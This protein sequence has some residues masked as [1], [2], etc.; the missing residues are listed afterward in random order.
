[1]TC[2]IQTDTPDFAKEM[3]DV[4][5]LFYGRVELVD[6]QAELICCHTD[7]QEGSTRASRVVLSGVVSA[8]AQA[9]GPVSSDALTDKRVH[10]R[11]VKSALYQ[12]L[13][14]ATGMHPPWGSLTGIR[15]TRLVYARMQQ[16]RTLEQA[17]QWAQNTFDLTAAKTDLLYQVVQV[18]QSLPQPQP[19]DVDIYIGIPFCTTRC[20]YC[21]FISA[22][23]GNGKLLAP[24]TQALLAEMDRAMA[25][26]KHH[27]LRVRAFYMGG[28]TPTSLPADLLDAILAKARPWLEVA[29]EATVEAGRPDTIDRHKLNVLRRH[30][31]RRISINPQTMHDSTLAVIGRAHTRQ[32]TEDAYALAR[33]LGFDRINMDLIAGLPGETLDM[34]HQ[35]LEWA[36]TLRPENLTVHSLCIK[37]SSDMHR[38]QDSLPSGSVVESMVDAGA[39]AA[40]DMGMRAYYLYRQK[41]MAGNLENV[42]YAL[43]GT[44][45]L[46]NVDTMEDTVSILA[47][48]AGGISKR[49]WPDRVFIKRAP[50]V[51]EIAHYTARVQEMADR[52]DDLW[53]SDRPDYSS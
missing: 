42:G 2:N 1:M 27:G 10:K 45:C 35:T 33:E 13:K 17:C 7:M 23:V 31:I 39:S 24:Y 40:Q 52:K 16:G 53:Q 22:Q 21:S 19:Q 8:S 25:L 46:Y 9:E 44:A 48:G 15:P 30:G 28:G 12:A 38:W 32:Q 5:S 37:R 14:Q 20:R 51:K 11:Q 36:G 49:V 50:N 4:I 18:Q 43:P 6:E 41:H 34:F 47:M 26:V 3:A 29:L